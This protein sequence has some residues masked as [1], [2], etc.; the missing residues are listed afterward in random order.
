MARI[1]RKLTLTEKQSAVLKE[2][3]TSRTHRSDHATRAQIILLSSQLKSNIQISQEIG[4]S[5]NTVRKWRTRGKSILLNS[6]TLIG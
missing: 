1:S 5:L 6:K 3:A 4:I 2:I